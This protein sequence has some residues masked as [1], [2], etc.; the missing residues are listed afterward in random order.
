MTDSSAGHGGIKAI[1]FPLKIGLVGTGY[2]ANAR[3]EVLQW[4][5]RVQLTAVAGH[6]PTKTQAFAQTYGLAACDTWEVLVNRADLDLI[7]IATAN[8]LHGPIV[9][10]AL[11][12]GKHVVVEFPLTLDFSEA[13][14][15][16]ARA[17]SQQCLL[18][19]EHIELLGGLHQASRQF[20]P[21][22]GAVFAVDYATVH[23]QRP[24]PR[25]WTY[26]RD[27]FGFPLIGALSRIHRLTDLFGTV[28]MV[29]CQLRYGEGPTIAPSDAYYTTCLCQAQ[30]QFDNGVLAT[31]TYGK[32]EA[33]WQAARSLTI[34]GDRGA[35][36]FEGDAGQ[37]VTATGTQ[38]LPL[39]S[40]R[41]LFAQDMQQVLAHLQDG[42]PLYVT[43]EASLY[44]LKVADAARQSAASQ[45]VIAIAA[46]S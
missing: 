1:A 44:A 29:S 23:P 33:L 41:G 34:Q 13:A 5:K 26:H 28:A 27:W 24:A 31:V 3:A 25:R 21:Q 10:A 14:S 30:L 16:L 8:H 43:P 4:D 32:G 20:L 46:V 18:H 7:V 9:R 19:V 42:T 15:L 2:A 12:A 37:L 35:L 40:R 45:Q 11:E 39:S 36:I 6:S 22:V 17:R 38:D